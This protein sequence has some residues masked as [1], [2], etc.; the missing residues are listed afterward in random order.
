MVKA[1]DIDM[2]IFGP[3]PHLEYEY[4]ARRKIDRGTGN[5]ASGP[6]RRGRVQTLR[7][8]TCLARVPQRDLS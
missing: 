1:E 2:S 3:S 4:G 8:C 6:L 5:A 7:R